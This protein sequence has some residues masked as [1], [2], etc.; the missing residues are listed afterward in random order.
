MSIVVFGGTSGLQT[1]VTMY[2]FYKAEETVVLPQHLKITWK[3]AYL[4]RGGKSQR[5]S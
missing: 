4:Q 5:Q 1:M 3:S 2:N